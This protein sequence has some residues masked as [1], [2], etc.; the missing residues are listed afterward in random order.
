MDF[1]FAGILLLINCIFKV[2]NARVAELVDAQDLKSCCP[3]R[4]YGF[5]SRPGH[6]FVFN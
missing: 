4:Q 3:Q 2:E 5:D 6:N 1:L